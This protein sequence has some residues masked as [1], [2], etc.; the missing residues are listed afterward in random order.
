VDLAA[1]G[2]RALTQNTQ[3]SILLKGPDFHH[4]LLEAATGS[5]AGFDDALL[6]I[7]DPSGFAA[8][9]RGVLG[10]GDTRGRADEDL[11]EGAGWAEAGGD[12]LTGGIVLE[13][14]I[15]VSVSVGSTRVRPPVRYKY[16]PRPTLIVTTAAADATRIGVRRRCAGGRTRASVPS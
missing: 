9:P 7:E 14:G 13:A 4:G 12:T 10:S 2:A 16:I 5:D 1:A 3:F 15:L 8:F 6:V 11:E